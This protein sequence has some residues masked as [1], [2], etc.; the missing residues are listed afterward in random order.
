MTA[1]RMKQAW[2]P[3]D[4]GSKNYFCYVFDE[5]VSLGNININSLIS[6]HR[7]SDKEFI[8]GMP[9]FVKG[10]ELIVYRQ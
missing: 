7:I 1:E 10:E 9:I 8:D 4:P 5:E 2:Y 6:Y 3:S